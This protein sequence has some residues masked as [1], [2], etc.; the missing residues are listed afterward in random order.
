MLR[1]ISQESDR[2]HNGNVPYQLIGL[3]Q[4][5]LGKNGAQ[6]TGIFLNVNQ[7]NMA[8]HHVCCLAT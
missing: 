3:I 7:V 2:T 4:N 8:P 6:E 5:V 1:F